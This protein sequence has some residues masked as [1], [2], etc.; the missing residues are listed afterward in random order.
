LHEDQFTF[1][2]LSRSFLLKMRNVSDKTCRENKNTHFM[3]N[4][5]FLRK[6]CSCEMWKKYFTGR[7]TGHR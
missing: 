7:Q 1:L 2:I 6:S 4:D 3:F 5:F